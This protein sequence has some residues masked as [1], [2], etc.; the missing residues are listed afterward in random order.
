[1]NADEV[2]GTFVELR[3]SG[4]IR[5][6]GVS[7]FNAAQFELLRSRLPFPLVTNQIE[8]SVVHTTPLDDGTLDLCS[9]YGIAPMAWSPLNSGALF[10]G[11]TKQIVRIRRELETICREHGIDSIDTVA[12]AWL[13]EHPCRMVP[14]VGTGKIERLR[15]AVEAADIELSRQEWFRILRASRGADVP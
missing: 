12:L 4:K 9:R 3:D 11:R 6:F 5:F 1:M 7:N 13:L 10:S 2:A 15:A 14:V 8:C